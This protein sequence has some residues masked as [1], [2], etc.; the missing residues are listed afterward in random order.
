MATTPMQ[1]AASPEKR[2]TT[3][4]ERHRAALL[5]ERGAAQPVARLTGVI[6]R[7]ETTTAL[8]GLDLVLRAGEIVA[9]LGPN[10]AGKSTAVRL[11]LGLAAPTSGTVRIFGGDP[12]EA[13]ARTRVGAMLQVARMV[14]TLRVREHLDLFR[15]YYPRPLA[16]TEIVRF[17]QLEGL[18]GRMFGQLSGGQKQRV[19]FALALCGDPDLIFL[20]EPTVGMDIEARRGLWQQIRELKARGKTVL[21]TTHYLEEA[22]ALADRVVVIN[23][24]RV[25]SAGTPAE[26][27]RI[28][29]GRRIR[30]QTALSVADLQAMEGVASVEAAEEFVTVTAHNAEDVVREMLLRDASLSGLEIASPALEDAFLAL[31]KN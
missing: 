25:V 4:P 8:D 24:G 29:G 13:T 10:G 15:S 31:T 2:G 14:E 6:K 5:E 1:G 28:S 22:D 23:K 9:L 17:A 7:Y 18:E 20:D 11:M 12:R 26:I 3:T 30:C 16:V 21:L 27:K 19:L